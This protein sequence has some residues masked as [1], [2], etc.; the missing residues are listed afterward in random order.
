MPRS[1][2]G[3]RTENLFKAAGLTQTELDLVSD[4]MGDLTFQQLTQPS[5]EIRQTN[6]QRVQHCVQTYPLNEHEMVDLS[7]VW[8]KLIFHLKPFK[9]YQVI[10][11]SKFSK[12]YKTLNV[13]YKELWRRICIYGYKGMWN[14]IV[15]RPQSKEE[16]YRIRSNFDLIM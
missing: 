8:A 13:L 6:K 2:Q 14:F 9:D 4:E 1:G 11:M 5:N 15:P 16:N 10:Y 12:S 3:S 7:T